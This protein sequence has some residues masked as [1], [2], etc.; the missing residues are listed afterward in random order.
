MP[1]LSPTRLLPWVRLFLKHF[2]YN[3]DNQVFEPSFS[4]TEEK[5]TLDATEPVST[6]T[7]GAG[8]DHEW[9]LEEVEA[10]DLFLARQSSSEE[11]LTSSRCSTRSTPIELLPPPTPDD[12]KV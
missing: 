7:A 6:T 2:D 10:R 12:S 9:T 1:I 8:G 3:P 11:Y 4:L 5:S